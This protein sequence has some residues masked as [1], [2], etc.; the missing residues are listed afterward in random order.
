MRRLIL[1]LIV[2][3]FHISSSHKCRHDLFMNRTLINVD[4]QVQ[5]RPYL[6]SSESETHSYDIYIDYDSINVWGSGNNQLISKI[7]TALGY[8][9]EAFSK[10]LSVSQNVHFKFEDDTILK[11]CDSSIITSSGL[12]KSP[13]PTGTSPVMISYILLLY[14]S[15]DNVLVSS[16]SV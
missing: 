6:L 12:S 11:K 9:S 2:W 3:I 5:T 15:V 10:I 1:F 7:K 13:P 4:S 14:P 16:Y 8:V